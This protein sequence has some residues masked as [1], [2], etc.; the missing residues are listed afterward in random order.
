MPQV[1]NAST[2][3]PQQQQYHEQQTN[4]P[5]PPL[6]SS[7]TAYNG[8]YFP[9]TQNLLA[10]YSTQRWSENVAKLQDVYHQWELVSTVWQAPPPSY[11][12]ASSSSEAG[13]HRPISPSYS[14]SAAGC[15]G[16]DPGLSPYFVPPSRRRAN[17]RPSVFKLQ[18]NPKPRVA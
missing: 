10:L 7:Q 6:T 14:Y 12:D 18:G 5:L 17:E 15:F 4:F 11:V 8:N 16:S 9:R 1:Y 2:C 3:H 13:F